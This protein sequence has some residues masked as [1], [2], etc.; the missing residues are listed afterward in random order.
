MAK[1]SPVAVGAVQ[2]GADVKTSAAQ[3]RPSSL[4]DMKLA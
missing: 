1:K 4:V 3:R 2:P